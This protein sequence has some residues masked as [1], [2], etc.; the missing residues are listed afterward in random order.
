MQW[1]QG[2]RGRFSSYFDR[3]QLLNSLGD[4]VMQGID[5]LSSSSLL[6]ELEGSDNG[7]KISMIATG[8]VVA[9]K[10][11]FYLITNHHVVA[12]SQFKPDKI[13]I[14]HHSISGLGN[15]VKKDEPL[16]DPGGDPRWIEHPLGQ[17]V[18]VIALPIQ[19]DSHRF[20]IYEFDLN[21]ANTNMLAVPSMPVSIIG[22]LLGYT[23]AG[24]WP[25]WK[26]GHIAS[27]VDLDYDGKPAFLIDATTRGGMSGS[28][29]V[30]RSVGGCMYMDGSLTMGPGV[31]TR[32]MGVYSGRLPGDS[33][34]GLVWRPKVISDILG[35]V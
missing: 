19:L 3:K 15:W 29:V 1:P 22:F 21:L 9:Y 16:Y 7:K 2:E 13:T 27:D 30:L 8:F 32:F 35:S 33:N 23:V 11:N 6:L 24:G 25:I 31:F 12:P 20:L 4:Y 14:V 10:G 26:T 28:P 18:D 17:S 5:P 34:I